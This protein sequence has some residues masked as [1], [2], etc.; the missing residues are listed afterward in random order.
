MHIVGKR[1]EI[2]SCRYR[3]TLL[4]PEL[5][6]L[7]R[8]LPN[9]PLEVLVYRKVERPS[10]VDSLEVER[11]DVLEYLTINLLSAFLAPGVEDCLHLV[12]RPGHGEIGE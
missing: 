6:T 5:R 10:E 12:R 4:F 8:A 2:G 9:E 3:S 7:F 11:A 1:Q